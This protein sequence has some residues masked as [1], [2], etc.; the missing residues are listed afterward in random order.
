[1]EKKKLIN[2]IN[3]YH[4]GGTVNA[5]KIKSKGDKLLTTFTTDSRTILGFVATSG[6]PFD[7]CE[8]GV[9]NTPLLLKL[10]NAM[11]TEIELTPIIERSKYTGLNLKDKSLKATFILSDLDVIPDAPELQNL[12]TTT[13]ETN[14]TP[15]FISRFASA[16]AAL[17]DAK[18]VS[19][20]QQGNEIHLIINY[21]DFN[22]DRIA[23]D[24]G[25]EYSNPLMPLK[26]DSDAFLS[27]INAN[28]DCTSGKMLVS[29][30]GLLTLTFTGDGFQTKYLLVM[31][32]K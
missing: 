18:T 17:S 30:E 13:F 6:I 1:M 26:F 23:I 25:I 22:S 27:I 11:D 24:L 7:E 29:E 20:V 12:P 8:L 14:I 31:L 3:K 4:L 32:S 19:F 21:E 15:E 16:K 10:L 9:Y 5:V 2:F 28:K